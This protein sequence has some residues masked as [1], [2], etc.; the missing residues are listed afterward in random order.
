V[1]YDDLL[2]AGAHP[3]KISYEILEGCAPA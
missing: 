2:Q 3:S 1:P